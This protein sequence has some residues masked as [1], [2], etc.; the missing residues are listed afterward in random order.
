MKRTVAKQQ[1]P[2]GARVAAWR[3]LQE[4]HEGEE[5]L[6]ALRDRCFSRGKM[7]RRDRALITELTQGVMRH[8]LFLEHNV[9]FHLHRPG[10]APPE[11]VFLAL[12]LGAYQLLFL[13]RIPAH[14][15]VKETVDLVKGSRYR[16]FA[17]LVNAVLRRMADAG[18]C[19]MPT[20]DEDAVSHIVLSTSNPRWLVESLVS[21]LGVR[22]THQLLQALNRTPP[23]ALRTNTLKTTRDDLLGELQSLGVS[24]EPGRLSPLSVIVEDRTPPLELVPFRE[25]RCTVQDDGAQIIAP[26]LSPSPAHRI[27]DACAAPGG[28][29]GHLAQLTSNSG[30]IVA[31]D[32]SLPRV[33]MT[34]DS[35][36]R[37]AVTC[38]RLLAA[39]LSSE[40]DPFLGGSFDR[41]L[42]DVP[43]SGTGVLRRHP[44]GKWRKDPG[45]VGQLA[46]IQAGLLRSAVRLL[47]PGGRLL[48]TTCSLLREE[49]EDDV[50]GFVH[51][52]R[53]VERLDLRRLFPAMPASLFNPSGDLRLWP[54]RH[55]CDGFFAALLEKIP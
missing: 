53:G 34:Q 48:Y 52:A 10:S 45:T 11:P 6:E 39:D 29:T 14:A 35:L 4:W 40:G 12:L 23:L 16:G 55:G 36:S 7:P 3:I 51:G 8:R 5:A 50:E 15:A 28:K 33:R 25:G 41:I 26:L 21:Q 2:E 30:F 54:H 32:L 49:N 22:E 43:C 47:A 42:L 1:P 9:S 46:A 38:V 18:T 17:P 19:P 44:E 27:L 37:L 24:A 20:M 31:A 13:H